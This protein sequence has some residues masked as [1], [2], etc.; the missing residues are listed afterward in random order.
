MGGG[1]RTPLGDSVLRAVSYRTYAI[2]VERNAAYLPL[3]PGWEPVF[4]CPRRCVMMTMA[5]VIVLSVAG[6][7]EDRTSKDSAH[8]RL[9]FRSRPHLH[10][11]AADAALRRP[12]SDALLTRRGMGL[13]HRLLFLL[14]HARRRSFVTV[15]A[16]GQRSDVKVISFI[17]SYTRR[18][19]SSNIR[20]VIAAAC[21]LRY[22]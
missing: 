16:Q 2:F 18:H 20:C 15:G 12:R 11:S 8:G 4:F 5:Y 9:Q 6:A 7:V 3:F 17:T 13:S 10:Q 22:L 19:Q 14:H 21:H 1:L